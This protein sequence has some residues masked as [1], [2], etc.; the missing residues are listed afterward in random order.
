MNNIF[1]NENWAKVDRGKWITK[2]KAIK[3]KVV[4]LTV[5][6][7]LSSMDNIQGELNKIQ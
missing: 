2:P 7:R 4:M 6:N 3:V 1:D 5:D